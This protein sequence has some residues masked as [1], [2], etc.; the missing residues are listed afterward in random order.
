M[1]VGELGGGK[2]R[3]GLGLG[4]H[5]SLV[6]GGEAVVRKK[7]VGYIFEYNLKTEVS[8]ISL[9]CPEGGSLRGEEY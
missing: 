8:R 6:G 7:K 2:K 4:C 1:E 9:H 3:E 5:Y